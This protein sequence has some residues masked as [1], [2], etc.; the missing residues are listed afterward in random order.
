MEVSRASLSKI[1]EIIVGRRH[2]RELGDIAGL[3]RSID[4]TRASASDRRYAP[5]G[6]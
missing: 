3:A 6:G 5:T 2:R 1:D 4:K